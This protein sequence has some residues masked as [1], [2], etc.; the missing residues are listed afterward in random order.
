VRSALYFPHTSI[1]NENLIRT[2]LLLWD[3]VHIMVPWDGF[4]QDSHNRY[5]ARALELIGVSHVPSYEEKKQA[6]EIVEDFA[7]R[8]LPEAFSYI[9]KGYPDDWPVYPEKLLPDTWNMLRMTGLAG[10]QKYGG[11]VPVK[12]PTGLSLLSILADCCAGE[13]LARITDQSA[14]Y[15]ILTGLL[16]EKPAKDDRQGTMEG[17]A[18]LTLTVID[19]SGIPLT[20]LIAFREREEKSANGHDLRSLR[21]RYLDRLS[22]QA[23]AL[24]H[25]QKESDRAEIKRQ[26]D[27]DMTDDLRQLRSELRLLATETLTSKELL[28]AALAGAVAIAS[29]FLNFRLPNVTGASGG[30]VSIGGLLAVRTKFVKSRRDVLKNH[31]M[32]YLHEIKGGL[33][34]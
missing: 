25:L 22:A 31:P 33:R 20:K 23:S 13:S 4:C 30:A 29:P 16:A 28:V 1:Q 14:A 24:A 5:H 19:T 9:S 17:L 2:S 27:Q 26:F 32:A 10:Q 12:E 15:G 21:H 3:Q 7:T 34:I 6:H 8:P 18:A 11:G